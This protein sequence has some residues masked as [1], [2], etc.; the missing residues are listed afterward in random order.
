MKTKGCAHRFITTIFFCLTYLFV[1]TPLHATTQPKFTLTPTTATSA[2]VPANRTF[3]VVYRVANAT[4]ITRQLTMAPIAGVTQLTSGSGVCPKAFTLAYGES[5]LLTLFFNGSDLSQPITHGPEICKTQGPNDN[6][7][8]PFL[9]SQPSAEDRLQITRSPPI[10]TI[11]GTIQH[12]SGSGLSGLVLQNNG[13]DNLSVSSGARNFQ[14]NTPLVLGSTYNVTV[15]TQPP[16]KTCT[17]SSGEGTV[18]GNVTNVLIVC[19][20]AQFTIGGTING[21]KAT[22]LILQNNHRDNLSV[23]SGAST[24]KFSQ[25]IPYENSYLVTVLSSPPGLKCSA[26]KNSGTVTGTVNTVLITCSV[27]NFTIGGMISP[28]SPS[29]LVLQNNFTD[30]YTPSSGDTTFTFSDSVAFRATYSVT[31]YTQPTGFKCTVT[32]GQGTVTTGNVTNVLVTCAPLGY[33]VGGAING[34][35]ASGLILKN[36]TDSKEVPSGATNFTFNQEYPSGTPYH[37]LV[38]ASPQG[39]TCSASDNTGT[40]TGNV[41]SVQITCSA[42]SFTIGGTINGLSGSGL[43]LLNNG[44]DSLLA[45]GTSFTF[46]QSVSYGARYNVTVSENPAGQTCTPSSNTGSATTNITSV[47]I[48]CDASSFTI[49]GTIS[50]LTPAGVS[51]SLQLNSDTP[52]VINSPASNYTFPTPVAYHSPYTVSIKTN[53]PGL[54]CSLSNATGTVTANVMNVDI[55]C[56]PSY[57][58]IINS[59]GSTNPAVTQC[60]LGSTG[61][62]FQT[63][64]D[65]GA[66]DL[67]GPTGIAINSTNTFAYISNYASPGRISRCTITLGQTPLLSGCTTTATIPGNYG[68]L[69]ITLTP[70]GTQAMVGVQYTSTLTGGTDHVFNCPI[71]SDGSFSTCV[72]TGNIGLSDPTTNMVLNANVSTAYIPFTFNANQAIYQCPITSGVLSACTPTSGASSGT[73]DAPSGIALNSANSYAFITNYNDKYITQCPVP[74]SNLRNCATQ[75]INSLI[76]A[77]AIILNSASTIAYILHY[78]DSSNTIS[79]VTQCSINASGQFINCADTGAKLIY[80]STAIAGVL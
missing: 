50:G 17:V 11:G 76:S 30:N 23:P 71:N 40:V 79:A 35:T 26:S 44:T 33:T 19:E 65:S 42:Q 13:G 62:L 80:E 5:C 63:C 1:I 12:L 59:E 51:L 77:E 28:A 47:V 36:G 14:F 60:S 32:K 57:V 69:W 10:Y 53:P 2:I 34:L 39:L 70:D 41:Y 73:I 25:S 27:A 22:G 43:I 6:T 16:G 61:K 58:F 45:S 46:S 8:D 55:V 31:V 67:S 48:T 52:Y 3:N 38:Y 75:N 4:K 54:A 64:M 74:V 72:D 9:C 18:T 78:L 20:I 15:L 21:L 29:G 49:G 68:A 37:V 24:F 56:V 7:P 66:T